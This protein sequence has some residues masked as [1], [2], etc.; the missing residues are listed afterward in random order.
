[1]QS[2][3]ARLTA[4][5]TKC[6]RD[7]A[8]A[9][10]ECS[11]AKH[12]MQIAEAQSLDADSKAEAAVENGDGP[13]RVAKFIKWS[14]EHAAEAWTARDAWIN[15]RAAMERAK[16]DHDKILAIVN[17]AQREAAGDIAA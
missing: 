4:I 9:A 15:A 5:L 16:A 10:V 13:E 6:R 14:N 8:A 1:M 11:G 12:K 3:I 7:L 17:Q 2:N